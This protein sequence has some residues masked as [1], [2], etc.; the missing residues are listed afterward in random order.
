MRERE[1]ENE[2]ERERVRENGENGE[3][4]HPL[5]FE[6]LILNFSEKYLKPFS[7]I[8]KRR[9]MYF[10]VAALNDRTNRETR[11]TF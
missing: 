9:R 6:I 8:S 7:C 1:R 2:K 5:N 10:I 4:A 11:F 3:S